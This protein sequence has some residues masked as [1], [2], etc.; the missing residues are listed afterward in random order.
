MVRRAIFESS[1]Y[2]SARNAEN[3]AG[4]TATARASEKEEE[5]TS[6]IHELQTVWNLFDA[7]KKYNQS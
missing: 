4:R 7:H 6:M 2:I 3:V 5:E 1:P